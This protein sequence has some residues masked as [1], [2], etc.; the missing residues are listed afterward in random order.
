[1]QVIK[2]HDDGEPRMHKVMYTL[3]KLFRPRW[4]GGNAGFRY[5]QRG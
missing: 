4:C 5:L 2:G 1:M 3:T